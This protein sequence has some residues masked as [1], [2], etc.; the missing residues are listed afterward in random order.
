[1][2]AYP[3][4]LIA[5]I[6]GLAGCT[7]YK[8]APVEPVV[9]TTPPPHHEII[10]DITE[11]PAPQAPVVEPGFKAV[12]PSAWT[13]QIAALKDLEQMAKVESSNQLDDVIRVPTHNAKHGELHTVLVGVYESLEDAKQVA[14]QLPNKVA[15]DE[16]WIRSV[17]SVQAV[18]R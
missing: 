17:A 14:Q 10:V 6:L 4:F 16:P 8:L 11:A 9:D 15:G 13:V 18:M 1:M 7:P 12:S 3:F 5:G 2:K